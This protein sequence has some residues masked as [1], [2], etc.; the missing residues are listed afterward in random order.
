MPPD[1]EDQWDDVT[2]KFTRRSAAKGSGAVPPPPPG[3]RKPMASSNREWD[4]VLSS[5]LVGVLLA[6]FTLWQMGYLK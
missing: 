4:V 2:T 3:S 1:P 5:A 6:L